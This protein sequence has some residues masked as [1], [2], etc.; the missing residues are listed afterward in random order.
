MQ[1]DPKLD[2]DTLELQPYEK[3]IARALQ[4]YG[5]YL[6]DTGGTLTLYAAHPQSFDAAYQELMPLEAFPRLDGIPL[7]RLRVLE[8]PR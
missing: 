7:D 3:T 5:M 2:L 6:G 4:E 8:P 1:L